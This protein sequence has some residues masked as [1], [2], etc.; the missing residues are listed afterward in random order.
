MA[1]NKLL[2]DAFGDAGLGAPAINQLVR[3]FVRIIIVM[4]MFHTLCWSSS[5]LFKKVL[6][7]VSSFFL[8]FC[9]YQ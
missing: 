8:K 3:N 6:L 2:T 5:S 1:A 4:L 9:D 7:P